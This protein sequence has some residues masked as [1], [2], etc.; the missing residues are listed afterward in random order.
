MLITLTGRTS[1]KIYTIP[2]NYVREGDKLIVL[3]QA[4]RTWWKNLRG[5]APVVVRVQGENCKGTGETFE[6]PEAVTE[7][8]LML[9]QRVQALQTYSRIKLTAEG[10]PEKPEALRQFAKDKVIVRIAL[11]KAE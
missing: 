8:L 1:G 3:S 11:P 2:V 6:G 10:L 5:G 9:L 7:G 4:D